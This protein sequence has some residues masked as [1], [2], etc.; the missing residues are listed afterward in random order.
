M[1]YSEPLQNQLTAFVAFSGV[2]FLLGAVYVLCGFFRK[3]FG[4]GKK[5][6]FALDLLFC[7]VSFAAL[8][9]ASLAFTNGVWRAP[10]LAAATAGFFAFYFSLARLLTI[11]LNVCASLLRSA[12][13]KLFLPFQRCSAALWRRASAERERRRTQRKEKAAKKAGETEKRKQKN[14]AKKEKNRAKALAKRTRNQYN[15]NEKI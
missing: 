4:D 1:R 11:R 14:M 6:T 15:K 3:L 5:T 2:G 8:F 13:A 12:L 7:L 9:G 10:D